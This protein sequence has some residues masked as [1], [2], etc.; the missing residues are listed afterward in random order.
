[1]CDDI[2]TLWA[3]LYPLGSESPSGSGLA[4]MPTGNDTSSYSSLESDAKTAGSPYEGL[5]HSFVAD[6]SADQAGPAA[7]DGQKIAAA[8][9][10]AGNG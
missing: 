9:Q 8:S 1:M 7:A 6:Q 3:D 10:A 4:Q 2:D 5:V